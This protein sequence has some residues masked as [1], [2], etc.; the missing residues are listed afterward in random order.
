MNAHL[1]HGGTANRTAAPRL[2]MHAF[3]CRRDKPQQQYQKRLLRP[4]V[5]NSLPPD[6]RAILALD[7]PMN[8][9]LSSQTRRPQR[10]PEMIRIPSRI[11]LLVLAATSLTLARAVAGTGLCAGRRPGS[12][13]GRPGYTVRQHPAPHNEDNF[14]SLGRGVATWMPWTASSPGSRVRRQD[15]SDERNPPRA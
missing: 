12:T 14:T 6:L 3:Y 11:L 7:D 2:A 10:L 5:Q 13:T 9:E 15:L 8:D 4:E 1:W